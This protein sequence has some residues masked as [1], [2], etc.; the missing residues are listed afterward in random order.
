M[1]VGVGFVGCVM[2]Y[3]LFEVGKFVIVI[4]YGGMDVGF[5]I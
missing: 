2:V 5:L 1:I 3:C 4:E